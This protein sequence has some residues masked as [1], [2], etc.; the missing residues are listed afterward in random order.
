MISGFERSLFLQAALR[1]D[2]A[3]YRHLQSE[4]AALEAAD[5]PHL[6][7]QVSKAREPLNTAATRESLTL[8]RNSF[9]TH[10]AESHST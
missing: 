6:R 2:L 8:I 9:S 5:I 10:R 1:S 4:V 3:T 7:G